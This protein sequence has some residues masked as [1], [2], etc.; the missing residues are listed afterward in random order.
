MILN[1][2]FSSVFDHIVFHFTYFLRFPP[3][4]GR[5]WQNIQKSCLG[6]DLCVT[7]RSPLLNIYLIYT[8]AGFLGLFWWKGYNWPVWTL[9]SS[10]LFWL[11]WARFWHVAKSFERMKPRFLK[12]AGD[13]QW[14]PF[15]S[16]LNKKGIQLTVHPCCWVG[17]LPCVRKKITVIKKL[18]M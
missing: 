8:E 10:L 13:R 11:K 7:Q 15:R 12:Y 17:S 2:G 6:L 5:K 18:E 14:L 1:T 16:A 3:I 4:H 9:H